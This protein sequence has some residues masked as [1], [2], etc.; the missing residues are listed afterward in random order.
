MRRPPFSSESFDAVLSM[1]Q[2]FGYFSA[3][4]NTALL[5]ELARIAKPRGLLI[6]DLY[7]PA[8]FE[9]APGE[10]RFVRAGIPIREITSLVD[11]R[12]NVKL[13]YHDG[14]IVDEFE[15]Q[16]FSPRALQNEALVTG[17]AVVGQFADFDLT[18]RADEDTPR[19]QYVLQRQHGSSVKLSGR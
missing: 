2:S 1:W 17:W 3:A 13:A 18:R 15:W 14:A 7:N 5:R 6:L 10:R 19:I 4:E 16:V 8:F 9:S 12:L 11:D